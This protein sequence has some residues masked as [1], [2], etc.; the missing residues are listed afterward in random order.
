MDTDH[1]HFLSSDLSW[2]IT[3]SFPNPSTLATNATFFEE[4]KQLYLRERTG[5]LTKPLSTYIGFLSLETIAGTEDAESLLDEAE[6][7][8]PGDFL[9]SIYA[10]DERLVAGFKAQRDVLTS[11][12]RAGEVAVLEIPIPGGGL[13]PA[14]MQKPLSRG[15]VR[16][17]HLQ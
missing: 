5:P 11:A 3:S 8:S 1:S 6:E 13:L 14:S 15:T 9:P 10:D 12:I 7:A 2:N 4:A 16:H 17:I